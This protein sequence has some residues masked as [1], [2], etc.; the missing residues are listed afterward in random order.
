MTQN[1]HQCGATYPT[2]ESCQDRFYLCL[3]LEYEN[4]AAFGA[5]HHLTVTCFMLQHNAYARNGWLEARNILAQFVHSG[6]EP[7]QIRRQLHSQR[8]SRHR[9]WSVTKG[10]KLAE[11][12]TILWTR[13]IADV[14]FDDPAIYCADVTQWAMSI[15][16]DT[17]PL[18]QNND[19][20]P[21]DG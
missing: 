13:T 16:A 19:F 7:A 8:N 20:V 21:P 11:L 2:D 12:D 15:L 10:T 3:A 17:E 4:P 5:V 6:V 9:A 1:C 18:Y 14:R